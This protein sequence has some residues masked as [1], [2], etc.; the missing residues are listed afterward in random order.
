MKGSGFLR[1]GCHPQ[2][3]RHQYII[4]VCF[5]RKLYEVEKTDRER[6]AGSI[7]YQEEE[8]RKVDNFLWIIC[9]RVSPAPLSRFNTTRAFPPNNGVFLN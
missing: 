4:L 3:W 8:I 9:L 6:G 7:C 2:R 5:S 1:R